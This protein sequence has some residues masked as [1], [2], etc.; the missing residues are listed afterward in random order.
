L[1]SRLIDM[2]FMREPFELPASSLTG[3]RQPEID[4]R[5]STWVFY[6]VSW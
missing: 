1:F 5:K 2:V 3:N 4:N 6:I